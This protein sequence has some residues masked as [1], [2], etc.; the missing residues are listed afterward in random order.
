M[1]N[2]TRSGDSKPEAILAECAA[3]MRRLEAVEAELARERA[4]RAELAHTLEL[5]QGSWSWKATA[6][7]RRLAA[8]ARRR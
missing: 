6:W 7:L 2:T 1:F 8:L 4:A 3:Q 5:V